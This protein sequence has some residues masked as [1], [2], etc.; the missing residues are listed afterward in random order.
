MQ[1]IEWICSW[2]GSLCPEEIPAVDDV[3][4]KRCAK[5]QQPVRRGKRVVLHGHGVR[6]R[7]VVVA[8]VLL[9]VAAVGGDPAQVLECWERRYRCTACGAI[10]VVLPKGVMPRYLY[11]AAAIVAAF[12]LVAKQPVGQGLSQAEAYD[13]QGMLRGATSRAF[14][15]PGYYWPSLK[16]WAARARCRWTGWSGA[17]HLGP[18]GAVAGAFGQR[19]PLRGG[20]YRRGRAFGGGAPCKRRPQNLPTIGGRP[21]RDEI[22]YPDIGH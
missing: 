8:P 2:L 11:S 14:S 6:T 5:C 9:L 10:L 12:F 4:P 1:N 15:D 13:R 22:G 7:M 19:G 21:G 16:R 17:G 3:Q 18:A 20:A